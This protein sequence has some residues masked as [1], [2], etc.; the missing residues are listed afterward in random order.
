MNKIIS[1]SIQVLCL[2][3]V[4]VFSLSLSFGSVFAAQLPA[5]I[6]TYQGRL[7]DSG[8]NLLGGS[9]TTY[10]FKF[11]IWNNATVGSGT[12][13]WP[14][15][16]PT[17]VGSTVRQGVF[18]VN[19][20]DT[21]NG[22]PDT[23]NL[24]FSN[25]ANLYL[26][27]EVSSDNSTFE[28][29]SPRQQLTSAAFAR[30][31]GATVG[32]TTPSL[33]GTTT[34][35]TNSF[36]TIAATSSNSIPLSIVGALSQVANLFQIK[37]SAGTNL[38]SV[39]ADGGVT[40]TEATTTS[41]F[42]TTASSTNLY[43][44]NL[45]VGS[46]SGFLKATAGAVAAALIDLASDV[47]GVLPVSNGGT[48]W[49]AIQSGA[50]PYG[51]GSSALA[52][53]SA[54]TAGNV[55]AL[56]NGVPAWTATSTLSTISGLLTEAKG[57]TNQTGYTAGDILYAISSNTLAKLGIGGSGQVLKVSGGLPAWGADL[58]GSGGSGVF[59]STTDDL[60]TEAG[61][62]IVTEDGDTLIWD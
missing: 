35:A 14:T 6:F 15:S 55:L 19:V 60:L 10:Y 24:D 48:G 5:E 31:A 44:S 28:T 56:V 59:A 23:L 37:N 41:F 26:Q 40:A 25:Y 17:S 61:D 45:S 29:L 46:L 42:S 7:A 34:A 43:T 57:G 20:G 9:G 4:V 2:F 58:A 8:G 52:T 3:L 1:L 47:T 16:A 21:A 13:V 38:F 33:F 22:Y 36:V 51:N 32:T 49:A 50:I 18:T 27:I 53:T 12:R 11:S 30:V 62:T 54:G 39:G